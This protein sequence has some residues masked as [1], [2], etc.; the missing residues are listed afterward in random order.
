MR[1][2][3]SASRGNAPRTRSCSRTRLSRPGSNSGMRRGRSSSRSGSRRPV[4]SSSRP[5]Q[6]RPQLRVK[7]LRR[8][9]QGG[10]GITPGARRPV[11]KPWRPKM[12]TLRE[13][14]ETHFIR[15]ISNALF[16]FFLC[17]SYLENAIPLGSS[18]SPGPAFQRSRS[19]ITRYC[20]LRECAGQSDCC[21]WTAP[22]STRPWTFRRWK[23]A[24]SGVDPTP[25]R[26]RGV[27][28]GHPESMP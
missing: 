12:A 3:P 19:H 6:R 2:R 23:F 26:N 15:F 13:G 8:P 17:A 4:F 22:R 28:P 27:L 9:G 10:G 25:F 20:V 18:A 24:G 14:G 16:L 7:R 11:R 21:C 1:A 5:R